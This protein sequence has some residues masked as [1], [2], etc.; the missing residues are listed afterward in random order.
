M[1]DPR[2][3]A[4]G[5]SRAGCRSSPRLR[6]QA[7]DFSGVLVLDKPTGLTS[8]QALQTIRHFFQAKKVGHG[9]TLDPLATGLLLICFGRATR[10]LRFL[11]ESDKGYE[12][13]AQLGAT[14]DTGDAC[15]KLLQ[16]S[17]VSVSQK[18]I[19]DQLKQ[20]K[21]K[22]T[23]IPP[24]YSALK[25]QGR[26]LHALAREGVEIERQP[27]PV[28]I[29]ANDF[30]AY[31]DENNTVSFAV[32]C[33][34]G[35]YVRTLVEDLGQALGCGAHVKALRRTLSGSFGQ[36]SMVELE[37]L[38]SLEGDLDALDDFLLPVSCLLNHL[39]EV[40]IHDETLLKLMQGQNPIL[41]DLPAKGAWVRLLDASGC[42]QGVGQCHVGKRPL[43]SIVWM[44]PHRFSK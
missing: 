2:L 34:K 7:R 8:N 19:E 14:T 28:T 38:K 20:F 37:T 21:G 6:Y 32:R 44:D 1:R 5:L 42:L 26:P 13:V 43:S 18:D 17:P 15:G 29:Y 25:H 11:L 3:L 10:L 35:T 23:Q 39:P 36:Q 40:I 24:M 12:V 33:S 9:G 41:P 22:I 4:N 16:T 27:R 31:D 30:R